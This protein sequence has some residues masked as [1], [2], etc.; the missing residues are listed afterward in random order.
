MKFIVPDSPPIKELINIGGD[1]RPIFP[2]NFSE[3]S[4]TA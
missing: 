4:S 3:N 1:L 2:S